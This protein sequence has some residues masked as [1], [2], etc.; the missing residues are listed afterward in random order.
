MSS[1]CEQYWK[2]DSLTIVN[3]GRGC[4]YHWAIGPV[5]DMCKGQFILRPRPRA[6]NTFLARARARAR[7]HARGRGH[8]L[9]GAGE[10]WIG[11]N[12]VERTPACGQI[13]RALWRW[14]FDCEH[15]VMIMNKAIAKVSA[16][17]LWGACF[18]S[19]GLSDKRLE[20]RSE[21]VVARDARVHLV[22]VVDF[23]GFWLMQRRA[24]TNLLLVILAREVLEQI[25]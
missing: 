16:R 1:R 4:S 17:C 13:A 20:A 2:R 24:V 22:H 3:Q 18:R 21:L 10:V 6:G 7:A 15:S 23:G 9:A 11:L 5:T 25:L 8:T 14:I 12:S 19:V